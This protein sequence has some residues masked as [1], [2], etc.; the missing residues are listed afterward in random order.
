MTEKE[1][2]VIHLLTVSI[3]AKGSVGAT[4]HGEFKR[5]KCDMQVSQRSGN[6]TLTIPLYFE[7][8][9]AAEEYEAKV[10][11]KNEKTFYLVQEFKSH[12]GEFPNE[13]KIIFFIESDHYPQ[14]DEGDTE[15]RPGTWVNVRSI[16][17]CDKTAA[18]DYVE[19]FNEIGKLAH[20]GATNNN[21][22]D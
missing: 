18:I 17:I 5:C 8:K 9:A 16:F 10:K 2:Q 19:R 22:E 12:S 6:N 3:S 1:N 7:T 15:R 20:G 13:A 14:F 21:K 11:S 4:Y